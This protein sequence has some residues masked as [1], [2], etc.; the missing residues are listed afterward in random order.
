MSSPFHGIAYSADTVS[1]W[2]GN[3]GHVSIV[4]TYH[5]DVWYIPFHRN[6]SGTL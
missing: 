4:R 3:A 1:T 5:R 6:C 2:R